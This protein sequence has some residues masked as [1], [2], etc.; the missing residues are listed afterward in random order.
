M[1]NLSLQDSKALKEMYR[2]SLSNGREKFIST[3]LWEAV[4]GLLEAVKE[5]PK[6][7]VAALHIARVEQMLEQRAV[8]LDT[9]IWFDRNKP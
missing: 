2:K 4:M 9:S 3:E 7:E 8:Y 6:R 1:S 5:S